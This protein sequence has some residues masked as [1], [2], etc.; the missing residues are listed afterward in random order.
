ML[1]NGFSD[2]WRSSHF[3]LASFLAT[4]FSR[5]L[6]KT[7]TKLNSTVGAGRGR[8]FT[9]QGS[10]FSWLTKFHISMIFPG[11][12]GVLWFFQ[13]FRV[14]WEPCYYKRMRFLPNLRQKSRMWVNKNVMEL[15]WLRFSHYLHI[16]LKIHTLVNCLFPKQNK[17]LKILNKST[18]MYQTIS[19]FSYSTTILL[20]KKHKLVKM[21]NI[22]NAK[23]IYD[24]FL[25]FDPRQVFIHILTFVLT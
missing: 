11:F 6:K 9:I 16:F 23:L 8:L 1:S 21:R 20:C 3:V 14:E 4:F 5:F 17:F 18:H 10:H 13:V 19:H 15:M 24:F 25:I 2:Q 12:P 22:W 7:Q